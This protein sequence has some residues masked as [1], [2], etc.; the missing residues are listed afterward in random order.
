MAKN[1]FLGMI[2]SLTRL[3][4]DLA[5][6]H[7]HGDHMYHLDQFEKYYMNEKDL[8]MF[9]QAG[10]KGMLQGKDYSH[11]ELMPVVDG[12]VID[13][14]GGYEVE[15]FTLGGSYTRKCSVCG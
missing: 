12:S 13:L 6:T 7:N 8:V 14:G 11:C 4:F 1:D 5:V 3:P 2:K 10:L 9:D 15:V